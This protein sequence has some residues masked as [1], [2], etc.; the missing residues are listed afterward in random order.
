MRKLIRCGKLF[1]GIHEE[2]QKDMDVLVD[3]R[4]IAMVGCHLPVPEGAE[5]MDLRHLTVTPG[6]IDAHVHGHILT[7]QE[8]DTVLFQSEGY[9]TLA[10]LHNAQ[11]C[12]E[13]G[14]TS[15]R[16]T[17]LGPLGFG[18][19]DCRKLIDRGFFPG[20]RMVVA[21]HAFG[22]PGMPGDMSMHAAANPYLSDFM[23]PSFIGSGADFFANQV[24]REIKYGS[25]YI[26]TF[27]SGSFLSPD[28][29]PDVCYLSDTELRAIIE[30]AH[31]LGKPVTAHVYPGHVMRR[32]LAMGI[33]GMEHGAL[34][35]E[36]TARLYEESGAYLVSTFAP[37]QDMIEENEE[38][39][40]QN[41]EDA[42]KK[43]RK[44]APLLRRGREIICSSR[45]RLGF[46]SDFWAVHQPYESCY[47]YRCW[48]RSGMSALRTLRAA[49]SVN[50]EILG[51]QDKVGT[52]E[53]GKL[54]D[55]AGWS[56]DL[57]QDP[58]AL[59]ECSFVMK[60]GTVYPTGNIVKE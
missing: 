51:I 22:C 7:W 10:Y 59:F 29:G 27:I 23:Q 55:L 13:R 48:R 45:I 49:T 52:I 14:F 26:K 36:E 4:K 58:D 25:D 35:D 8:M 56:R 31:E 2:W 38:F 6:L 1:D 5:I 43:L 19:V 9:N 30:T 34:M 21:C 46:G 20:A 3:D 28:G 32:L 33:D 47:E 15:I 17:G 40:A 37:F 12:L 53:P 60:E 44:Y 18:A 16:V 42:Q 11:R 54:A 50:A 39:I 41:T 24:R 57:E